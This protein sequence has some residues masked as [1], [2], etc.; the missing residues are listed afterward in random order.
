MG[1][2]NR[3]TYNWLRRAR[4]PQLIQTFEEARAGK[5]P[6][7]LFV[8]GSRPMFDVESRNVNY[9]WFGTNDRHGTSISYPVPTICALAHVD[10]RLV[11]YVK[12]YF[13]QKERLESY[14]LDASEE[15][16]KQYFAL[17]EEVFLQRKQIITDLLPFPEIEWRRESG[18]EG[19]S[20]VMNTLQHGK[21]AFSIR[22]IWESIREGREASER[23]HAEMRSSNK[24]VEAST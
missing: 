23:R 1:V 19:G 17:E 3:Q 14:S 24:T 6:A 9:F 7:K 5:R 10:A 16:Q 15:V 18:S 13:R 21:L 2:R 11:D 4:N 12:R 8:K 20:W 22:D